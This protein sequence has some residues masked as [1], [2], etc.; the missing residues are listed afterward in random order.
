M[1]GRGGGGYVPSRQ[2][3]VGHHVRAAVE[4]QRR[5]DEE[6]QDALLRLRRAGRAAR[7]A[8]AGATRNA[9]G[10]GHDETGG[11]GG[12][13][14]R[15]RF[16]VSGE[17]GAVRARRLRGRHATQEVKV[18][19]GLGHDETGG[20]TTGHVRRGQGHGESIA[21]PRVAHT[22]ARSRPLH[23]RDQRAVNHVLP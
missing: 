12:G 9:G 1:R 17:L 3:A 4:L 15:T 10:Q 6:R 23:S 13:G 22:S 7:M 11:R 21:A 18:T 16:S 14:D 8:T 20:G 19:R 5:P 2:R